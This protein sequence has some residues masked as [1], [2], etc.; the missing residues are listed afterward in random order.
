MD[1]TQLVL[2]VAVGLGM[3]AVISIMSHISVDKSK[4]DNRK[5]IFS[6][7]ISTFTAL[8]VVNSMVGGIT[9]DNI[10]ETLLLIAGASFFANKGISA[11]SKLRN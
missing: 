1:T 10:I 6:T 2:Q 7:I 9:T 3:G 8:T 5:F 11:A 4:W